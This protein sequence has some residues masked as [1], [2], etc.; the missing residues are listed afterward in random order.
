MASTEKEE[1]KLCPI[2]EGAFELLGRK[3]V[4][5]II[6]VLAEKELHFSELEKVIPPLSARML[7]V[8]VKE[9]EEAG[10]IER[11]VHT[12]SPVRVTYALT[13]KGRD[14]L[15]VLGKF[16]EWAHRWND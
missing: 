11:T 1:I 16:V 12:G 13:E 14:L 5:L 3:W 6:H 2:V 10:L 9:L 15:P 4:G 8:R 7:A